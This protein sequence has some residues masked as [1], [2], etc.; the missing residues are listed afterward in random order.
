MAYTS[1]PLVRKFRILQ[2][3]RIDLSKFEIF[4]INRL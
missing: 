3:R 1:R 4:H 2:I